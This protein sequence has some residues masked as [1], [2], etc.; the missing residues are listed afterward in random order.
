M[1]KSAIKQQ[2]A[3]Q[4]VQVS[5][6]TQGADYLTNEFLSFGFCFLVIA[7]YVFDLFKI[8]KKERRFSV[9][10]FFFL[11]FHLIMMICIYDHYFPLTRFKNRLPYTEGDIYSFLF[12]YALF[13]AWVYSKGKIKE[14]NSDVSVIRGGSLVGGEYIN[15]LLWSKENI[16]KLRNSDTEIK[17]GEVIFPYDFE[18]QHLL[19]SGTTG[20]GKTQAINK[21]LRAIRARKKLNNMRSRA[22]IADASGG[23]LSRF[24]QPGDL[25]LNPFDKRS[26][27]WS[28][29]AE[30]RSE[31]DC[32]RIAKAAIPD[33]TGDS[34]EWHHYAQTLLAETMLAMHQQGQKS[35]KKLLYYLTVAE[36]KELGELLA[37]TPAAILCSRANEKMLGNTRGI[38]ATYLI[39][40]RY[41]PDEG[42]FSVRE[43]IRNE[44]AGNWLFITYRDD[45]LGMLRILVASMLELG[46]V[47]ALSLSEDIQRDLWFVFDEVDSLGK[48]SS[49]RAGL[50]KLRKYGCKVALGLQTISQLRTTY[51]KDEAQTL[52]ANISTKLILRAG[53]GETAEYFSDEMGM[54]E[55]E[56]QNTSHSRG[57]GF[58]QNIT[59]SKSYEHR[60]TVLAS[61]IS[62]LPNLA[63]YLK[64]QNVPVGFVNLPYEQLPNVAT[65][66]VEAGKNES[67]VPQ[68]NP[69]AALSG[70]GA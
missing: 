12:V 34:Q 29:F 59:E 28:P 25:I 18:T 52:L 9:H 38:I 54:Q 20:S 6:N 48:V 41:L 5:Q 15:Q 43:W 50:T 36:Y 69:M 67:T 2:H 3:T 64:M 46:I 21:V 58:S 16:K 61:E 33:G 19:F 1:S 65:P 37:G 47:E 51:G 31:Y 17:I 35:I 44:Y 53:D 55:I 49:L 30:I 23:F 24:Y 27:Q 26:V 60:R 40:W 45:Q 39:A 4:A 42:T 7:I 8:H 22:L 11:I 10:H 62:N 70:V 13:G 68:N 32:S 56:R 66:F 14:K 63:G 57:S